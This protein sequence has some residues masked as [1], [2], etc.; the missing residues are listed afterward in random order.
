MKVKNGTGWEILQSSKNENVLRL[1]HC[2]LSSA[3]ISLTPNHVTSFRNFCTAGYLI[4]AAL[5]TDIIHPRA[6]LPSPHMR[7]GGSYSGRQR[8]LYQIC[9][10]RE[11]QRQ[12]VPQRRL[13]SRPLQLLFSFR[14]KCT[15]LWEEHGTLFPVQVWPW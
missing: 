5:H 10:S 3:H 11:A 13:R 9:P 4:V 15:L 7:R 2:H 6:S 1:L 8:G 12:G 14:K